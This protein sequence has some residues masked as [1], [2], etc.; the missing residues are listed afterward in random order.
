[1]PPGGGLGSTSRAEREWGSGRDGGLGSEGVVDETLP[2]TFPTPHRSQ[3]NNNMQ[4]NELICII[5]YN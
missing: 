1:M 2:R 5:I 4:I 3:V